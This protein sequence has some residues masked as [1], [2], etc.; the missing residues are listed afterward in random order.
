MVQGPYK[1][2]SAEKQA[3]VYPKKL[4]TLAPNF[5]MQGLMLV[6]ALSMAHL[7]TTVHSQGILNVKRN[8]LLIV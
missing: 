1:L 2:Y 5:K 6:V 7:F 4:V 3:R 8:S